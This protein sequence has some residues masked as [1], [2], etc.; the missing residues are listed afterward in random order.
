MKLIG[1]SGTNGAGK[2]TIAEMLVER[3][4]WQFVSGS[5][6]LR[7][8]LR[9]ESKAITRKNLRLLSAQWRREKGLGVL[10]DMAVDM[11]DSSKY[12]GL[13]ISS[14]RNYGEADEVHRLRGKVIWVDADPEVRYMRITSRLRSQ[15]DKISYE[16][17]LQ[18]ERDEMDHHEGDHHTLNLAGVKERADIFLENSGSDIEDF[19]K[20]TEKVLKSYLC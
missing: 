4:G 18:H 6:I 12:P 14:I 9:K 13:V 7:E 17:F 10:I 5:D 15:E 3:C 20:T 11:F 16:E 19:K 1:L 8:E 2:D